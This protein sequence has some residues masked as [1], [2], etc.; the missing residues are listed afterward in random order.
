MDFSRHCGVNY[1][2]H[3]PGQKVR[4]IIVNKKTGFK[5]RDPYK[6]VIIRDYRHKLFYSNEPVIPKATGFNLPG[7]GKYYIETGSI[8]ML[9]EPISYKPLSLPPF[10]R[11]LG[12]FTNFAVEFGDNPHK[13]TVYPDRKLILFDVSFQDAT[14]PAFYFIYYHELAHR[15]YK[16]EKYTDRLAVNYML[17]KGFNPYQ[18]GS[19][20]VRSLSDSKFDRKLDTVNQLIIA[21]GSR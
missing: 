11:D 19:A 9:Q 3:F 14:L 2:R 18:I 13:C 7:F 17:H 8:S 1:Y 16:T 6:P 5:I 4:E 20:H 12:D 10:E 15:Y 21:N